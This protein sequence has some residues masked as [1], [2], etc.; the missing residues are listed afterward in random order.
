MATEI[1]IP[2]FNFGAGLYYP[3]LLEALIQYKRL[4]VPE[5]TDESEFEPFI[6]LLRA[7]ALVGH[8]NNVLIDLVAN[9]STLPTAKLVEQVRNMLR[10]IDYEL[11]PATPAQVDI[12]YELSRVFTA[13]FQLIPEAAQAAT[14]K[15]GDTAAIPFE[16]LTALTISRTDQHTAVLA[17]ESGA[18]TDYTA[19]ANSDTPTVD[20]FVPW[21][22]P[23]VG[24]ALYWGHDTAMWD[25]LGVTLVV[26]ASNMVGVWEVYDGDFRKTAPTSVNN[27]GGSLE[28]DLATL[29][30]TTNR[31]G[32]YVR[33]QLNS[34]TAYED[35]LSTWN[36]SA[37][38]AT[39]GLLGQV[40]PSTDPADYTIGSD[41]TILEEATDGTSDLTVSGSV[42]YPVPQTLDQN[43]QPTTINS[44]EAYWLRYRIVQA[45][46]ATSPTLRRTRM[47]EGKQ[48]VLRSATQG[49]SRTDDPLGSSTGL[50]NQT[51]TTS[52]NNYISGTMVVTVDDIEW[53]VVDNF[54][55]SAAADT[56]VVL[57]LGEND[58]ATL[59]FGDGAN[60]KIPPIGVGNIAASYRYGAAVDGNVGA[61]T[62]V[63]DKTG[64]TYVNKLFNPR[65]ATG[66]AEAQG[67]SEASL[68]RAKIEGPASL[69]TGTVAIGPD[70]VITLT[71]A[72]VD[73]D[74]ASP[75][76][77]ATV[78][79]EGYGPKT[80]E[81]VVVAQGGGLASAAQLA[82]LELYFNGDRYANPPVAKHLIANHEVA[83]V[84]YTPKAIDVTATVYG[85][86]TEQAVINR[87]NQVIQ[88]EALKVDG[89]TYE[90]T[91]G[92]EV[93]LNRL[94]HE[95]FET[96]DSITNVVITTPAADVPLA[97]RELP[98]AGT[99]TITVVEP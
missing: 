72:F 80:I 90:W 19:K 39:V 15:E 83:A 30:G 85:D 97:A 95:I 29:L 44:I 46:G 13:A 8:M 89:V 26:A 31:Q 33:V 24:D 60:G 81:V 51:F 40:S 93:P 5:L 21:V 45:T 4:N 94:I 50:A 48:Y 70:D 7:F 11:R 87:L 55:N 76:G 36:G 74:G 65:Q 12:V 23:V 17:E 20:D 49:Q 91:F 47:D 79:E 10:L 82:A 77:R 27:L 9:E 59:T 41:W 18:F 63:V 56:H 37:N 98:V 69:R 57:T 71:V 86:V 88:P 99:M 22:T 84:N 67:A 58:R 64:L 14:R 43:W 78:F 25:E 62:V 68:E 1:T 32:T 6:Q 75:F 3:E 54:L 73:S 96:D 28:V 16:A 53:T 66:W 61:Q 2:D 92:G 42:E 52:K 35:V 38:I 34:T